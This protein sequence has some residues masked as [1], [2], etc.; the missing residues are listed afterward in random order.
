MK[1]LKCLIWSFHL[2]VMSPENIKSFFFLWNRWEETTD[3]MRL[4]SFSNN[5]Q[6]YCELW[7]CY[8]LVS[9]K[10]KNVCS[11]SVRFSRETATTTFTRRTSSSRRS[12]PDTF[13]CCRGS[14]T[15]A[16]P[17]EWSFWAVT[18]SRAPLTPPPPPSPP[19]PPP[20]L[21][22]PPPSPPFLHPEP[23]LHC[24]A[25]STRGQQTP[26]GTHPACSSDSVTPSDPP[27][28]W[29]QISSACMYITHISADVLTVRLVSAAANHSRATPE[30]HSG[31]EFSDSVTWSQ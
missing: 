16:S 30:P 8:P 5:N 25:L 2:C 26:A 3:L 12:T 20:P 4:S 19:P 28:L 15:S 10:L 29:S 18:S 21:T 23:Q 7:I 11:S 17:C 1:I 24:P 14:G 27:G 9:R 6:R 31:S 22:P 13:A